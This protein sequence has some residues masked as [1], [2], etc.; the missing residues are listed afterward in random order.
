[1]QTNTTTIAERNDLPDLIGACKN[2]DRRAQETLYRE[3]YGFAMGICRRYAH[4]REEAI[5]I[6]ND[7]F[8][9]IFTSLDKYTA[10]LSFR[11]WVRRIM[12]NASIDHFRRNEKHYHNIDITYSR[13]ISPTAD[14][15]SQLS[16]E[17]I[18]HAVQQL[19]ASYRV[20]F[21]LHIIEGYSHDEIASMLGISSGTSKS[22]LSVARMKLMKI[23]G[24]DM[25][26]TREQNG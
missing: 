3:F 4:S 7:G 8:Y 2:N 21:N 6:V 5:E 1:M 13:E 11:G 19:P 22:N 26:Q 10:G 9:K 12:V 20:V 16:E 24:G 14:A 15:V 25:K 18:M 17:E 23:L